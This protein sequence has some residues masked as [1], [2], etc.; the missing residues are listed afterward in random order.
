MLRRKPLRRSNNQLKRSRLKRIGATKRKE[1]DEVGEWRREYLR[2]HPTCEIGPILAQF[3]TPAEDERVDLHRHSLGFC[4]VY[5][6]GLHERK[7]RSQNGA[8]DDPANVMAACNWCNDFVEDNP[9]L[10]RSLGLL[11]LSWENPAEVPLAGETQ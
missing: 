3:N 2:T 1:I 11:V 7:K 9:A 5:V 4:T 8:L 6:Q 10:A